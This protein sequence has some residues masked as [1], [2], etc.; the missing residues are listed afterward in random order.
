MHFALLAEGGNALYQKIISSR[1][2]RTKEVAA[3]LASVFFT[4]YPN[5]KNETLYARFASQLGE[6]RI[7]SAQ[8]G[9]KFPSVRGDSRDFAATLAV[10]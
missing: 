1:R 7:C 6:G 4:S 8:R 3:V 10:A 2:A 5:G 9:A